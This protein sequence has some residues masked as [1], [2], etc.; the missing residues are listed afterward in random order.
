MEFENGLDYTHCFVAQPS[1]FYS[2]TLC[3]CLLYARIVGPRFMESNVVIGKCGDV[4]HLLA[5]YCC[6]F[7][8]G[9]KR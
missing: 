9:K 1:A 3:E 8:G 5:C 4:G 2:L 6:G 7:L